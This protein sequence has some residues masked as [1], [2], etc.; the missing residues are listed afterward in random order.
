MIETIST[1]CLNETQH[2]VSWKFCRKQDKHGTSPQGVYNGASRETLSI[3]KTLNR[4][5]ESQQFQILN[6][7]KYW[8]FLNYQ[9]KKWQGEE[10]LIWLG[11][12]VGPHG[13]GGI[14]DVI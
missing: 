3:I 1:W 2:S 8:Y 12:V 6:C 9:F 13:K 10:E 14:W 7:I 4:Y 11:Y 5:I